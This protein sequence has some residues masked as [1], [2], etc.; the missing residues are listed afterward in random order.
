MQMDRPIVLIQFGI[1]L[2]GQRT[3]K[4]V[5]AAKSSPQRPVVL[6][7]GCTVMCDIGKMPLADR[8]GAITIVAQNFWD[9]FAA[10]AVICPRYPGKPLDHSA[11]IPIP[12]ACA[13]RPVNRHSRVGEHIEVTWKFEYRIPPLASRSIHGVAISEP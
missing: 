4:T 7:P 6:R 12:T 3:M 5:P 10:C 11:I 2:V 1:P 8:V 13:L 9:D